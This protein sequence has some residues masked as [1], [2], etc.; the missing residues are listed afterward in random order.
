MR[1]NLF[2]LIEL[3]VVIAI[4]AILASM[5]LPALSKARMK[6]ASIKCIGNLKQ[7]GSGVQFYQM[8]YDDF[9]PCWNYASSL[10]PAD[11]N[12]PTTTLK[13]HHFMYKTYGIDTKVF[14]CPAT[15]VTKTPTNGNAF[16]YNYIGYGYNYSQIGTS[17]YALPGGSTTAKENTPAKLVQIKVPSLTITH[18]DTLGLYYSGLGNDNYGY[19]LL[20]T[21]KGTSSGNAYGGRHG[22]SMNLVFVDGHASS[23]LVSDPENPYVRLGTATNPSSTKNF[24]DRTANRWYNVF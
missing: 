13:W 12:I 18:G 14:F 7:I 10:A 16:L 24:W 11:A 15:S 20:N 5:L 19:Y 22:N 2:T 23:L 9:V 21:W 17:Q 4:I 6:A 8:D 3:L 1:K